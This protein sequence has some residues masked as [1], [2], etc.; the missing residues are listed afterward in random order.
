MS[1]LRCAGAQGVQQQKD[2]RLQKDAG[3][4]RF[5]L[6]FAQGPHRDRGDGAIAF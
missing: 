6:T 4:L 2:A 3:L 5:E 1:P